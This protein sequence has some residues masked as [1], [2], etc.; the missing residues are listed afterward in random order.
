MALPISPQTFHKQEESKSRSTHRHLRAVTSLFLQ[1][2]SHARRER[3]ATLHTDPQR[4]ADRASSSTATSL[5]GSA[6]GPLP[7]GQHATDTRPRE[8][9]VD[10]RPA[11]GVGEQA[12]QTPPPPPPRKRGAMTPVR[13]TDT[14]HPT[15]QARAPRGLP[16][17][18]QHGQTARLRRTHHNNGSTT[19][20]A[21]E[22]T[23]K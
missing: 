7:G 10:Q 15:N 3:Q 14:G 22:Q 11:Q 1:L 18:L 21:Q 8:P 12:P 5:P 13:D 23:Q 19:R 6:A 4:A 9:A 17:Q 2:H 20:A 16:P